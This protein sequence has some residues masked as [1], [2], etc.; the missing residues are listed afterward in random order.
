MKYHLPRN[1]VHAARDTSSSCCRFHLIFG[2]SVMLDTPI[3]ISKDL[4]FGTSVMLDT[5][6]NISKDE[7][8]LT[9]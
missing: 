6:I 5:P 3:N 9:L 7:V 4:I 1:A 8:K 2:T